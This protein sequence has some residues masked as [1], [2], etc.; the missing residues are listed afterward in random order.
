MVPY[1][2]TNTG[3][4]T[5]YYFACSDAVDKLVNGSWITAWSPICTLMLRP[6]TALAPG[7]TATFTIEGIDFPNTAP[8]FD[9]VNI[10]SK[11][12]VR[13]GLFF[14]EPAWP[15]GTTR[16]EVTATDEFTLTN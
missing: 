12:R 15:K 14:E 4:K 10:A 6:P 9:L 1:A 3:T 16:R 5:L 11:Y 13:V 8:R 7:A 2:V